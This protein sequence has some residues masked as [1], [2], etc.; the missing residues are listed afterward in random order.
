MHPYV[1]LAI[2]AIREHV[3]SGSIKE[4]GDPI[5]DDFN[6]TA[7]AFVSI[8]KDGRLRG[9]IGTIA[10]TEKNLAAEIIRNAIASSSHDR[11]F[12]PV[13]EEE[14]ESLAVSVDVLSEAEDIDSPDELDPKI[15]GV[16]VSSGQNRGLLLPDL[17]GIDTPE[18]QIDICRKKGGIEPEEDI[19]LQRFKVERFR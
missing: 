5:P 11:R 6:K 19:T 13:E 12:S 17:D 4:M 14:L 10:P 16:I 1:R 8:K 9:C 3:V 15:Y 7:G 2:D 18:Q